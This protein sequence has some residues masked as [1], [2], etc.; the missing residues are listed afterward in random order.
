MSSKKAKISKNNIQKEKKEFNYKKMFMITF[1]VCFVLLAI[2][3]VYYLYHQVKVDKSRTYYDTINAITMDNSDIVAVGSSDF[4]YSDNYHYTKGLEKAKIVKYDDKYNVSFEKMYDKGI[5]TTFMSVLS[6]KDGYIAVGSGTFTE[7]ENNNEGREGI[8]V[9]YDKDGNVVWEK[10]YSVVTN[11]R[12]NKVIEVS[13]GYVVVGQSIYATM[14]MGNHTTGGGIIVK[15]DFDG[16]EVWHNN[17]GGMKS[18]NFNDVVL[19]N[20]DL[21]VAGKDATD[22]ANLVKYSS[23]G[24]YLWHKNYSYTDKIGFSGIAYLD[25]ALY[26]VG[27][28]KILPEGIG[29]NDKRNT[30][31]T[32]ALVV[33]YDLNGKKL[34]EYTYG[35]SKLERFNSAIVV[36]DTLYLVGYTNSE[37]LNNDIDGTNEGIIVKM[38][39]SGEFEDSFVLNGNKDDILTNIIYSEDKFIVSGYTNSKTG[40]ITT[41]QNNGKDYFG[42]LIILDKDFNI[43]KKK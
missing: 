25:N 16:N 24:K 32:D 7:E 22:S 3:G 4:R 8:I 42:R 9:K 30:D 39:K 23:D 31:N 36:D 21:Y 5:N 18:G 19:V 33:K 37:D 15:Y 35:G 20:G 12:F 27:S 43:I 1:L 10:T 6:V 17:H 29:D 11:T 28:K 38:N 41:K 13:D 40:R 34:D 26:L 2:E 14:E